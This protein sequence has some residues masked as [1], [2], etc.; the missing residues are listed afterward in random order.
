MA[1]FNFTMFGRPV[2]WK[3]PEE[4]TFRGRTHRYADPFVEKA[5]RA[6][7][8]EAAI[9]WGKRPPWTGPVAIRALFVFAIPGS[10]PKKLQE[11]ALDGKVWHIAD[12][13]YDQ[14]L[15]LVMDAL[16][17]LIYVDDNQVVGPLPGSAKRYGRPE[18]TEIEV[19]LLDQPEA[20]VTPGQHRIEHEAAQR[21]DSLQRGLLGRLEYVSKT[22]SA[23]SS[24][25][26]SI[27]APPRGLARPG[28]AGK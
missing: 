26:S 27:V 1:R 8:K 19:L 12:P 14:L 23:G 15:K 3:R 2:R 5:K 28:G 9:Y 11:A 4:K 7:R 10:W 24:S 20:A 25:A 18:R 16:R 13:D 21:A 22:H 17:G 6:I